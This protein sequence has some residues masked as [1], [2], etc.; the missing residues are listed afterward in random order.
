MK[1]AT[2]DVRLERLLERLSTDLVEAT[3]SELLEACADL[4]IKPELKGSIA[5]LGLKQPFYFP[6]DPEKLVP[7]TDPKPGANDEDGTDLMRRQ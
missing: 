6:Y 5:F 2:P 4:G 1:K 3:D 7:S